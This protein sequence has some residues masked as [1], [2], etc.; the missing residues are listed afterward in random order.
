MGELFRRGSS[1]ALEPVLQPLEVPVRAIVLRL[2]DTAVTQRVALAAATALEGV[3]DPRDLWW[4]DE[5]MFHATL[6]HASTHQDPVPAVAEE[7]NQPV[8]H[9]QGLSP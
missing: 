5:G 8:F 3:V 4:Q 1:G 9:R 2:R 6:W 7:A